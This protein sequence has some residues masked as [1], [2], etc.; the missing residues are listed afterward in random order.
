MKSAYKIALATV[1][2]LASMA[3]AK[4]DS[5]DLLVGFTV[6][7]GNDLI[8]DIG[9]VSQLT[10]GKT[11]DL[12]SLLSGYNLNNVQWGVVGDANS[13]DGFNPQATW[14]TTG[15]STPTL[16]NGSSAF[17]YIQTP[18][19]ALEENS[20]FNGLSMPGQS[21]TVSSSD[22]N[23][24]NQQTINGTLPTQFFNAYGG[25]AGAPNLTGPASDTLWQVLDDN[26]APTRLGSFT[27]SSGGVLTFNV[28][29]PTPPPP[30]PQI[31]GIT[32]L[33]DTSTV[34]FTTTNGS[35]TYTLY[36]TNSA[37]LGGPL[38]SW[39]SVPTTVTGNGLTNSLQDT[40]TDPNRFYRVG[41]H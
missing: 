41:V 39:P 1:L 2:G 29:A 8:Y 11:W 35:F 14:V 20:P 7:S 13:Q 26:S 21:A 19:D 25:A 6:Q 32:R 27:L 34:F 5:Y 23:S 28:N 17:D 4:A 30:P 40:T 24:W 38:S 15:G 18:I 31:L 33:G 22:Q 37:G 3:K 16:I 12:S 36:Y 10:D 9:P